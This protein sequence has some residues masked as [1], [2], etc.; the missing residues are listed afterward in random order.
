MVLRKRAKVYYLTL[1]SELTHTNKQIPKVKR[2]EPLNGAYS[3]FSYI[4]SHTEPYRGHSDWR[5]V[6]D[7]CVTRLLVKF[8]S[9]GSSVFKNGRPAP[10]SLYLRSIATTY[11]SF[12]EARSAVNKTLQMIRSRYCLFPRPHRGAR[13]LAEE[14]Q[15][16]ER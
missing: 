7:E 2:L 3:S 16:Y 9:K 11:M 15:R 8:T 1:H 6:V 14:P 4:S 12:K 10:V 13:R 5:P